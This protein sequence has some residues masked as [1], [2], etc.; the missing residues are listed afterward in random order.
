MQ[1]VADES[2]TSRR[3]TATAVQATLQSQHLDTLGIRALS[4]PLVVREQVQ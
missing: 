1:P 3:I 4:T 2:R